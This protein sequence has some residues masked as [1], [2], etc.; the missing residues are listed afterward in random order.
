MTNKEYF[1]R[2]EFV[3]MIEAYNKAEKERQELQAENERLE[4]ENARIIEDNGKLFDKAIETRKENVALQDTLF[5]YRQI[6]SKIKTI[7]ETG[8]DKYHNGLIGA[9]PILDLITKAEEE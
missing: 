6:L 3:N 1:T 8:M 5:S 4:Q 2:E 9:K 7:A